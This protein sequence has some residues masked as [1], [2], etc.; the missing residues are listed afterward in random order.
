M[1]STATVPITFFL[2][3]FSGFLFQG[4]GMVRFRKPRVSIWGAVA[5]T[6]QMATAKLHWAAAPYRRIPWVDSS[7]AN[8]RSLDA[9][10]AIWVPRSLSSPVI[11]IT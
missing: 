6:E 3:P 9:L 8:T 4:D 11:H 1:K 10:L 2:C 7:T 5:G